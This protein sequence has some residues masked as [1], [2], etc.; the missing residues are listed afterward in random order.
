MIFKQGEFLSLSGKP[1][2]LSCAKN[3]LAK[4]DARR[5]PQCYRHGKSRA[6]RGAIAVAYGALGFES[7]IRASA[8]GGRQMFAFMGRYRPPLKA[9]GGQPRAVAALADAAPDTKYSARA[10]LPAARSPG[11]TPRPKIYGR[12][13]DCH[14]G[15]ARDTADGKARAPPQFKP[16]PTLASGAA[17]WS[18]LAM[19]ASRTGSWKGLPK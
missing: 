6:G 19:A 15:A 2:S 7:L 3:A 14:E 8:M 13:P 9:L 4:T 17:E 1:F 18:K 10:E 11:T 5:A 16:S 12:G